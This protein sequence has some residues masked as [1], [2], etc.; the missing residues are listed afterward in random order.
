M[1]SGSVKTV[2]FDKMEARMKTR[3]K[4]SK[5]LKGMVR[6]SLSEMW[7]LYKMRFKHGG[8]IP[9][10]YGKGGKLWAMNTSHVASAKGF[11]RPLFSH[12]SDM[13]SG[14]LKSFKFSAHTRTRV[15]QII[16]RNVHKWAAVLEQGIAGGKIIRAKTGK[17]FAIPIG[18]GAVIYRKSY[19]RGKRK[20][21][22]F[23]QPLP[24][25][26]RSILNIGLD[27]IVHLK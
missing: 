23:V 7:R 25:M 10:R 26:V 19:K 9:G 20:A 15:F 18:G 17:V 16:I 8:I 21:R 4:R 1:I 14:L 5:D 13:G 24:G 3:V 27:Y 6:R 2:G 22:K 12:N 11:N